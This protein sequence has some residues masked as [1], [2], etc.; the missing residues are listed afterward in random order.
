MIEKYVCIKEV[1]IDDI[2]IKQNTL[3]KKYFVK[4]NVY[5][6]EFKDGRP[7]YPYRHCS[8]SQSCYFSL[9]EMHTFF[10]K[11]SILDRELLIN[12]ILEND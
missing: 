10:I 12:K 11:K 6:F 5:D 2:S 1:S 3:Y 8:S 7:K 9:K 4:N